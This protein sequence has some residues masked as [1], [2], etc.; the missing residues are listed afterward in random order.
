LQDAVPGNI[1]KAEHFLSLLRR[2]VEHLKTRLKDLNVRIETPLTFLKSLREATFIERKPMRFI[3]ERL[4]SL[5]KTLELT[6]LDELSAL[7]TVAEFATILSS[8]TNG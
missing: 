4:S 1:R 2:L 6:G 5:V 3:S 8:Y 7:S